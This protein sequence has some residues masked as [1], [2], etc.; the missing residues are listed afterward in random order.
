[1]I[2]TVQPVHMFGIYFAVPTGKY[3]FRNERH[4][5][6]QFD[7]IGHYHEDDGIQR[8][9]DIYNREFELMKREIWNYLRS[10]PHYEFN[11]AGH[12]RMEIIGKEKLESEF[13]I[14]Q[15]VK[16]ITEHGQICIQ[17]E[18]YTICTEDKLKEYMECVKDESATMVY[19]SKSKSLKGK[20][21]DQV[22]Y[23]RQ[24]GISFSSALQMCIGSVTTSNLFFIHMHPGYVD[25]FTRSKEL[26]EHYFSKH[27]CAMRVSG[28]DETA[29]E[30]LKQI[31]SIEGYE[32]F[33]I[34]EVDVIEKAEELD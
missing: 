24:R 1:M 7:Y 30:Y 27:M 22:F 11:D 13:G 5:S 19:L 20:V 15:Q 6:S 9:F 8:L 33:E 23:L 17:P 21:A 32:D 10:N 12:R 16:V 31:H 4:S 18:E 29:D 34:T 3:F 26:M 25:Y 14:V 28:C 2:P